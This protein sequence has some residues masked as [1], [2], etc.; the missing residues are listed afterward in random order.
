MPDD[1]HRDGV[2]LGEVL[3]VAQLHCD[4]GEKFDFSRELLID[5]ERGV[6]GRVPMR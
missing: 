4:R 1:P 3:L 2:L 5:P 6:F